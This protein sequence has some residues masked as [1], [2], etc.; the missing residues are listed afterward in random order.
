[1]QLPVFNKILINNILH[2]V[3]YFN[4]IVLSELLTLYIHKNVSAKTDSGQRWA[5]STPRCNP[6]T[7]RI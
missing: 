4:I 6:V 3:I 1:V 5:G 2:T 7:C